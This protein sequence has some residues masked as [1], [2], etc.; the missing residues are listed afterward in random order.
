MKGRTIKL[1]GSYE[2]IVSL[3]KR[4]AAGADSIFLRKNTQKIS[5]AFTLIE[6]LVGI[7]IIAILAAMLLPALAR[8]KARAYQMSCLNNT[9]QLGVG[10]M[11]YISD[12][13]DV[14]PF[15]GSANGFHVED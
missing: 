12:N 15:S 8:A 6:F 2:R 9:K 3:P 13:D 11:L 7:A 14:F 10:T 5:G 4:A 1:R